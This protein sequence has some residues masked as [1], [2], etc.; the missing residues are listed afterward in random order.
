MRAI[1]KI[2]ATNKSLRSEQPKGIAFI[3]F[4]PAWH[5]TMGQPLAK[6]GIK[7]IYQPPAKIPTTVKINKDNLGLRTL[8][9]L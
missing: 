9:I 2:G 4:N 3:P 1:N 6:H 5:C 7:S 8:G